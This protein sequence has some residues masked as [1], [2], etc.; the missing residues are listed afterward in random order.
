MSDKTTKIVMIGILICLIIIAFKPVPS[1]YSN[2]PTSL[3]VLSGETVVQ[4]A[5]NRIAIV[6]TN[7]NSGMRGEVFV[8]E[9]NEGEKTFDLIGRYNYNDFFDNP[10][11]YNQ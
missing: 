5:E 8:L 11:K 3:D 2:F 10:Q 1:F 9:F 7:I 6:D 4:L